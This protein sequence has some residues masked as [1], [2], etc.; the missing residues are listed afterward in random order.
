[1]KKVSKM[2]T[3]A[4]VLGMAVVAAACSKSGSSK[5]LDMWVGFGTSVWRES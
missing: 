4:S 1:M 3:A 5:T 2:L